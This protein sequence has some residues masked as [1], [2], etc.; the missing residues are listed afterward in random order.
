V[1]IAPL[2]AGGGTKLKVVE[3]MASGRP[4]VTTPLGAEGLPRSEGIRICTDPRE[5]ASEV[6]RLLIDGREAAQ[7]GAA[8]RSA[9]DGLSWSSIWM[10]ASVDLDE[11]VGT[12]P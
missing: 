12:R 6:G 9:A 3:A 8:N 1:V 10:R 5:F 7:A 4:V 11:L 2:F